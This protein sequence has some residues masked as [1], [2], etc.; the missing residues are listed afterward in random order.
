MGFFDSAKERGF[1]DGQKE[2]S[3]DKASFNEFT[4]SILPIPTISD[5][6]K[7]YRAGV[8]H[9]IPHDN[10]KSQNSESDNNTSADSNDDSGSGY[11][12]GGGYASNSTS[13]NFGIGKIIR[14][15]FV[16]GASV[17]FLLLVC[18]FAF[19]LLLL[20]IGFLSSVN[21]WGY[22]YE[23]VEG[24]TKPIVMSIFIIGII[25]SAARGIYTIKN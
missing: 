10:N 21:G 14:G 23:D 22:S 19:Y 7:G 8:E 11:S 1:K 20:I 12:T 4:A 18:F 3:A 13:S 24:I 15:I 2:G 6:A 25:I 16:F 17:L 5:Y 9:H